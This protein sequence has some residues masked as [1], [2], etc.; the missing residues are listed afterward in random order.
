MWLSRLYQGLNLALLMVLAGL[1]LRGVALVGATH[2]NQVPLASLKANDP[3]WLETFCVENAGSGLDF[4]PVYDR[5]NA[6][7]TWENP[8]GDWHQLNNNAIY[9][10]DAYR[11]AGQGC[12]GMEYGWG[13]PPL[14]EV[15]IRY[16]AQSDQQ[17]QQNPYC[18]GTSCAVGIGRTWHYDGAG[19]GNAQQYYNV[20]IRSAIL[21]AD[22]YGDF[23]R[24]RHGVNHETSHVF[25][26]KDGAYPN[27]DPPSVAHPSYAPYYCWNGDLPWPSGGDFASVTNISNALN[28]MYLNP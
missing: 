15:E 11:V 2:P 14:S 6:T 10:E 12:N 3:G 13:G 17:L 27:C 24:R 28:G 26:L 9:F 25:G 7:L 5:I 20:Y 4:R 8:G 23:N 22:D 1:P 18:G 16:Y 19:S 21:A